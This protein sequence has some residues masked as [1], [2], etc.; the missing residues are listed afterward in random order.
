MT[1]RLMLLDTASL[2]FRSF[3]GVPTSIKAPDG[4]P[5][6][7]VRGLADFI[8]RLVSDHR[9]TA[10][11]AAWD[12]DW[13]PQFRVDLVPSYKAHRVAA[14]DEDVPD[15]LSVQVPLISELL[16]LSGIC[17]IGVDGFEADDVIATLATRARCPVAIV[18]G[19]RDLF[20]LVDDAAPVRVLYT[21][22][23]GV[24]RAELIDNAAVRSRYGV[25]AAQYADLALL[26][27]DPSDGLPGV[28]GVGEKTAAKLLNQYGTV[29]ALVAAVTGGSSGL[30]PAVRRN[31]MAGLPYLEQARTVVD[32][33]RD[34]PLPDFDPMLPVRNPDPEA[35]ARFAVRWGLV[36]SVHRLSTALGWS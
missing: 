23:R 7:A 35:L 4:T 25:D 10:L 2:Y 9:P 6:N 31:V 12:N 5:V 28:K 11:I 3:Y 19:D 29:E 16:A 13:R 32:V 36:S 30:S 17:R 26:R 15:E 34:V 1:D 24:G 14:D 27:G 33:V 21:A 22:A 8:S 18:T 20:Q